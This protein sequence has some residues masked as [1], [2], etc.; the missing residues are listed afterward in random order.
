[1]SENNPE[2]VLIIIAKT[3]AQSQEG[4]EFFRAN[5]K[6]PKMMGMERRKENLKAVSFSRLQRIP[7][8]MVIPLRE[9]PGIKAAT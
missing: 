3:T 1:L 8:E 6:A 2:M 4:Q 9:I 5:K 7:V